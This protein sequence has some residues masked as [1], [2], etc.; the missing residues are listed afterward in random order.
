MATGRNEDT[1]TLEYHNLLG[2]IIY[3]IIKLSL[4]VLKFLRHLP[5][6][7]EGMNLRRSDQSSNGMPPPTGC[8]VEIP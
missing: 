3:G 7:S 8:S 2:G 4:E 6:E 1:L 5:T